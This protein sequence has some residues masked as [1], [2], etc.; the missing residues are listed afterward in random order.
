MAVE[1]WSEHVLLVSP[2]NE[3]QTGDDLADVVDLVSSRHDYDVVVDCSG[4][5]R[6]GCSTWRQLFELDDV[7][8]SQGHRLVLCGAK[9]SALDPLPSRSWPACCVV[10][11]IDRVR[12]PARAFAEI[13]FRFRQL[14]RRP[15]ATARCLH[16]V[17]DLVRPLRMSRR[18]WRRCPGVELNS[19]HPA[20]VEQNFG[21]GVPAVRPK[22]EASTPSDH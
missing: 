2:I 17:A 8:R 22:P 4:V 20:E 15:G 6:M 13:A 14:V 10:L 5:G 3:W 7:L 16:L 1:N 9:A 18:I 19:A 12:W 11:K 21:R